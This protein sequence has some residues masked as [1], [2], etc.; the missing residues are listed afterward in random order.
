MVRNV[1]L[2]QGDS[3]G[4]SAVLSKAV[5]VP[6]FHC[7]CKKKF[8]P[9][10]DVVSILTVCSMA[11]TSLTNNPMWDS[12]GCCGV[13]ILLGGVAS[14]II[15]SNT[16]VLVG[17]SIPEDKKAEISNKLEVLPSKVERLLIAFLARSKN[18]LICCPIE[19]RL[20][21]NIVRIV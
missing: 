11:A 2:K 1:P 15:Y 7:I 3:C 10:P 6:F 21:I 8:C 16:V 13:G 20:S 18:H 17:K 14:F 19:Y 12:L 4:H 9:M 5:D